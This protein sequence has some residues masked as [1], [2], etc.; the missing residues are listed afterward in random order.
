MNKTASILNIQ[1]NNI[2][3][4]E[5]L[6]S[7]NDGLL[8]TPNIDILMHLQEDEQLH[9]IIQ[10]ADF[11]TCDSMLLSVYYKLLFH[12]HLEVIRGSNFLPQF[13]NYHKTNSEITI[14][15]F[16]STGQTAQMAMKNINTKIQRNIVVGAVSPSMDINDAENK[17]II[18]QINQ[19]KATVLVVGLGC[20]KQEKWITNHKAELTHVRIFMALGAT[21]DFE[22]GVKKRAPKWL[23]EHCLE[24]FYRLVQEPHRLAKRYLAY[25]MPIFYLLLKQRFALYKNPFQ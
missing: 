2:S 3:C 14:F 18:Q 19:S 20:P 10:D 24:W 8:V 15:L 17:H 21:I 23:Q 9:S 13:Y 5:L 25:D 12:R 22:A 16:G 11:V 1:I 4:D 7:L 6:H